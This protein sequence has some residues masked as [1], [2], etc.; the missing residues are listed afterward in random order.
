MANNDTTAKIILEMVDNVSPTLKNLI[1]TTFPNA[2]S[3]L[4]ALS[5]AFAATKVAEYVNQALLAGD[6]LNK[7][8]QETGIATEELGGFAVAA[9]LGDASLESFAA[10]VNKLNKNMVEAQDPTSKQAIAFESLGIK[11]V[12]AEGK[13]R[14]ASDVLRDISDKF[15]DSADGAGKSAA[16]M[17]L[18]GKQGVTMIPVLNKGSEELDKM[19]KL[20]KDLG[21]DWTKGQAESAEAFNDSMTVL[22]MSLDGAFQKIAKDLAPMLETLGTYLASSAEEGGVLRNVLDLL[23]SL[24]SDTVIVVFSSLGLIVSTLAFGF[25]ILGK[26]IAGVSAGLVALLSGDLTAAKNIMSSMVDDMKNTYDQYVDFNQKLFFSDDYKKAAEG[27]KKTIEDTGKAAAEEAKNFNKALQDLMKTLGDINAAGKTAEVLYQTQY[28]AFKDFTEEHKELLMQ[29]AREIDLAKELMSLA[30]IQSDNET[31][32]TKKGDQVTATANSLEIEDPRARAGYLAALNQEAEINAK[33]NEQK[34]EALK[35]VDPQVRAQMLAEIEATRALYAEGSKQFDLAEKMGTQQY[36]Q[37]LASK[38]YMQTI[39]DVND[40]MITLSETTRIYGDLLDEGK[41]SQAEYNDLMKQAARDASDLSASTSVATQTFQDLFVKNRRAMEDIQ[42]QIKVVKDAF[43]AGRI[44]QEE[45][46][47]S[48]HDLQQS[49]DDLDPTYAIDQLSKIKGEILNATAAFEGMF[50]DYI[51][52]GLQGKWANLG[53]MIK[54]ILDRMIA[55]MLAAQIQF[56]LFGDLGSTPSGKTA[57]STGALGSLFTSF[58]GG[59][60]ADGGSVAPGMSYVVGER[61]P[62][63]FTPGTGGNITPNHALGGEMTNINFT[64]NAMDSKSV[65][66]AMTPIQRELSQMLDNTKRKNN[67]K[68]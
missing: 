45:Y 66:Q 51:F 58:F 31:A 60:R 3:A 46:T 68:G 23:A 16:A 54:N 4:I 47:K 27:Q 49:Y 41:I 64:I 15:K 28:G 17:E 1:D 25:Q 32:R 21:F 50:S 52:D 55:N 65:L 56:A 19:A 42:E 26:T 36:D 37:I 6:A 57:S 48:M 34:V 7:L 5:V 29:K 44:T 67:L 8:A 13:L 12:D 2:T 62:E 39:G 43:A 20:S 18:M 14:S 22:N 35:N 40:K 30:K 11:T 53:D 38:V 10:S 33:L 24:I 61:G 63:V 9:A 59:F